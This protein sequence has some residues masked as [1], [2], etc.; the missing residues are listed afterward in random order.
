MNWHLTDIQESLSNLNTNQQNGLSDS[1]ASARI[2]QY[3][4]NELIE[5]GG[6]KPL[7]I[8]WEQLTATM[9][10]ILIAAA[11][12][13]GLLGDT[14][15]TIAILS[16]VALYAILG[17]TQEYRAEKAIAAL[18]KMSVPNVRVLRSGK[19]QELS[20]RELVPGDIIQLETGNVIPADLRL[21]EAVNLRIQEAALTGESEAIEK[22]TATLSGSGQSLPLGDRRNMGYMGTIVTQ[23]RGLALVIATGMQTELGKIADLIQ[24]VKQENTP[25]QRRLDALG[26]NLALIGVGIAGLIFVLGIMRGDELRHMLLTAV[27]VAVAIVPE[28]LPAVV[29]ITLAL[30]AQ[31]MLQRNALIRKLPAV[32]TLGSVTVICS[33]KTGTLTENR[34]TVVVLDVAGHALDLTEEVERDGT[35]RTT[36]GWARRSKHLF[37]WQQLAA[38]YVTMPN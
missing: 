1:E 18:K 19:L 11:I 14:K 32:E 35:L 34:M 23:G 2:T 25:L 3:G 4:L 7:Q 27:S 24:Q 15:N 29:T 9:V 12:A 28:G 22:H 6:R 26:K 20:A 31:R 16:I 5:R 21:L 13:A 17:F 10:L 33:D 30:G 8:L 36:R 38:H 37:R